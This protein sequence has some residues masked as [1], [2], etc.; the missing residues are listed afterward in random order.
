VAPSDCLLLQCLINL[1]T[2]LLTYLLVA[3]EEK[4]QRA[5]DEAKASEAQKYDELIAANQDQ[6]TRIQG[7]TD[8]LKRV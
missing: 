3:D 7:D 6:I 4:L 1:F 5:V 8:S 2:Y